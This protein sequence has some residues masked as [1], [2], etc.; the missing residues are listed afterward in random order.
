MAAGNLDVFRRA[1]DAFNR[2]DF[3]A[4]EA[5]CDPEFTDVPPRDWP[6]SESVTGAGAVWRFLAEATE[7]WGDTTFESSQATV[8]GE[9]VVALVE[10]EVQGRASGA[11]V[12]WRF[13]AVVSFRDGRAV[14]VEWY[15]DRDEA[16]AV[17]GR[18]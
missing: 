12:R 17:A 13:W 16:L 10:S 8:V 2:G 15:T 1:L 18:R 3:E 11:T 4:W 14:R 6:E 5:E 9:R 7:L